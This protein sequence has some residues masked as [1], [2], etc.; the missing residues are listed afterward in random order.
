[1][2]IDSEGG[3]HTNGVLI[4]D[5]LSLCDG[6]LDLF[7]SG[8]G[9]RP[10]KTFKYESY[11]GQLFHWVERESK[12]EEEGKGGKK[13]GVRGGGSGEGKLT[14]NVAIQGIIPVDDVR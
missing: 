9:E 14:G 3:Q 5:S 10:K 13:V 6:H 4:N 8:T 7:R 11:G 1:M 12:K 2:D